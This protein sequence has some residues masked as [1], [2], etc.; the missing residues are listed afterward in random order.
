M[1]PRFSRTLRPLAAVAAVPAQAAVIHWGAPRDIT[2]DTDVSTNGVL[3]KAIAKSGTDYP[4]VNGVTFCPAYGND[5]VS[6]TNAS[7]YA[8]G[9]LPVGGG[10]SQSYAT[11][12]SKND[13]NTGTG[14]TVNLTINGLIA[15]P[16][17]VGVG[18]DATA[19]P[20]L[21]QWAM[22][23]LA[24]RAEGRVT[25]LVSLYGVAALVMAAGNPAL[26][27]SLEHLGRIPMVQPGELPADYVQRVTAR[28]LRAA[29]A[30]LKARGL[31]SAPILCS[32]T[33]V[34]IGRRILGKPG[35]TPAP[36]VEAAAPAPAPSAAAST[37]QPLAGV[38]VRW[39]RGT[40]NAPV[41]TA[42]M[43]NAQGRYSVVVPA[44]TSVVKN[45]PTP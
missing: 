19:I 27:S 6:G 24:G 32:D 41:C 34:A 12:L 17:G 43:T 30:R 42:A 18:G 1:N 28:K 20:T 31:P 3:V 39:C 13:Y 38:S 44:G 7:N 14:S 2:G 22:I 40:T 25:W 26:S 11:L 35:E 9:S 15:D 23:L 45:E 16:G 10:I 8:T 37:A 36:K 21:S 33:T 5:T 4:T 29:R